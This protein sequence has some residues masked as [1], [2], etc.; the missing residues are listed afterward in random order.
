MNANGREF[1]GGATGLVL[2]AFWLGL[3]WGRAPQWAA[4][5]Q[6]TYGWAV[7]FLCGYLLWSRWV[8]KPE[9][10]PPGRSIAATPARSPSLAAAPPDRRCPTDSPKI[11]H[12]ADECRGKDAA[13]AS[14]RSASHSRVDRAAGDFSSRPIPPGR[15]NL[16]G[17]ARLPPSQIAD[18]SLT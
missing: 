8:E 12:T 6:Y 14:A 7:P 3:I 9:R 1:V 18:R 11:P 4:N 15:M 2:A 13:S 16:L 10:E 5:D 17:K